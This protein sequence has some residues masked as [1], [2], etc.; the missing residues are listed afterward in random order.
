[1]YKN[2]L[3]DACV[4]ESKFDAMN[5]PYTTVIT[6]KG[7]KRINLRPT[8]ILDI[9]LKENGSSIKGAKEAAKALLKNTTMLPIIIP[10]Y[11]FFHV[12]FS[13]GS[14]RNPVCY[15]FALHHVIDAIENPLLPN[16]TIVLLRNGQKIPVSVSLNQF[17]RRWNNACKYFV[18]ALFRQY[19]SYT[20]YSRAEEKVALKCAEMN[21]N[22]SI[23][24]MKDW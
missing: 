8:Q 22:Y 12:W 17:N 11:S 6:S 10:R 24:Q 9:E 4:L 2:Y 16:S 5:N 15:H 21:E 7:T 14:T 1:M 3:L 20:L 23:K 18:L 19:V 13:S